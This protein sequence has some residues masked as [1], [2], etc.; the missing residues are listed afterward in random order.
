MKGGLRS[1]RVAQARP[2]AEGDDVLVVVVPDR[3]DEG[4][5]FDPIRIYEWVEQT[6]VDR[7]ETV[8][9][10]VAALGRESLDECEK[11]LAIRPDGG[12]EAERGAIPEDDVADDWRRG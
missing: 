4:A 5:G 10:Q 2:G 7:H 11:P 9:A 12:T 3:T 1:L 6:R 8:K